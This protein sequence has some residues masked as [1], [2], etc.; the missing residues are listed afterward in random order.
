MRVTE[1]SAIQADA[2]EVGYVLVG[3]KAPRP[4][5]PHYENEE[6]LLEAIWAHVRVGYAVPDG[7]NGTGVYSYRKR[8]FLGS[9][10]DVRRPDYRWHW[11]RCAWGELR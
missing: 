1:C 4:A 5:R 9:S 10:K 11:R 8:S 6:L 3:A 7:G 2:K